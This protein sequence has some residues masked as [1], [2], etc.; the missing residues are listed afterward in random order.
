MNNLERLDQARAQGQGRQWGK[1]KGGIYRK[2]KITRRIDESDPNRN[3]RFFSRK[4]QLRIF[5]AYRAGFPTIRVAEI[6]GI[7]LRRLKDVLLLG[8]DPSEQRSSRFRIHVKRIQGV[9]EK[10]ALS[11][12]RKVA[13]GGSRLTDVTE[14][15]VMIQSKKGKAKSRVI[16]T[17]ITTKELGPVWQ[18]AAWILERSY[19]EY[20]IA[21]RFDIED[22]GTDEI[23][24]E[25]KN[26]TDRLF[27]S[28][29]AAPETK[30]CV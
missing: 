28:V 29:P 19:K 2:S 9:R 3:K 26:A 13:C 22:R 20:N 1:Y 14:K 6:A 18:A 4:E 10:E 16:E 25:I 12:I 21:K 8:K 15:T 17:K 27:A 23:A 11:V 7:Q 5:A 30:E 24:M